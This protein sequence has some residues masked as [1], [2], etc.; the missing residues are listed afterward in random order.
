MSGRPSVS[1][2]IPAY[3]EERIIRRCVTAALEQSVP[4]HEVIV[5]DNRSTDRTRTVVA[6]LMGERPDAPLRLLRQDAEQG[7][8][9][10]RNAGLDAATGEVLGRIDADSLLEPDWVE[11]VVQCFADPA[12][13]GATGPVHYYDMPLRRLGLRADDSLRRLS[14]RAVSGRYHFLFGS[15]MALRASAWGILRHEVCRDEDDAF[16]ED[17]DLSVHMARHRMPIRYVPGLVAGMSAR[18]LDDSP[19]DYRSYVLRFDRTY[20][21]HSIREPRLR[22]PMLIFLSI[23]FPAKLMRLLHAGQ[24][25]GEREG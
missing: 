17:I 13:M 5:V 3:N 16:H 20:R 15:N 25:A 12:V 8:V 2:I 10:T 14:L 21:A 6:E 11:R 18:R 9:P 19:R 4:A 1:I 23:Y 22:I 7:L 24:T